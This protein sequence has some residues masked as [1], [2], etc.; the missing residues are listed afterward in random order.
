MS[1]ILFKMFF[2]MSWWGGGGAEGLGVDSDGSW[3]LGTSGLIGQ[4]SPPWPGRVASKDAQGPNAPTQEYA[5]LPEQSDF[6]DMIKSRT[7]KEEM[8]LACPGGPGQH[9]GP[10]RRRQGV[11]PRRQRCE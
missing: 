1:G 10:A 3:V 2:R 8:V 11:W 9:K 7:L 4:F 6:A 5:V